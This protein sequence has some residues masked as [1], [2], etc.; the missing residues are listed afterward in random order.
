[1][2][3]KYIHRFLNFIHETRT[4]NLAWKT[5]HQPQQLAVKHER[6]IAEQLLAEELAKR[7]ARLRH[8]IE[9]LKTQQNAELSLLKTRCEQDLKDYQ[10]YLH[11]LEQLQQNLLTNYANLPETLALTIHN[12]AKNMLNAMWETDNPAEKLQLESQLIRF[13][14]TIHEEIKSSNLVSSGISIPVNTLRLIEQANL[15]TQ[16]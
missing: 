12:H 1:M 16:Y 6:K 15:T 8:E 14:T 4:R 9:L 10:Q 13:M 7:N 3:H 5:A 2:T 11:A